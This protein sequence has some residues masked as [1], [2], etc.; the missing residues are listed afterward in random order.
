MYRINCKYTELLLAPA[1]A[2]G[3]NLVETED[4]VKCRLVFQSTMN[5]VDGAFDGR[6]DE[7][8]N[9][10]YG[11]PFQTIKSIWISR[12]GSLSEYWHLVKMV[13]IEG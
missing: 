6:L 1:N 12:L 5:N 7:I 4:G 10:Q 11:C 8:C 9:E 3:G 2:I 13:K